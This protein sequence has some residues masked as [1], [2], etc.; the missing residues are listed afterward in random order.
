MATGGVVAEH[1]HELV[2]HDLDDHLAGRDG[3][4]HLLAHG[5][6]ANLGSEIAHH[7]E[8][9]VGLDQGA[10]HLAHGFGDVGLGQR[11]LAGELVENGAKPL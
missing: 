8:G 3:A 6:L 9:H 7:V 11:T 5:L 2:M 1:V 10:A 4:R